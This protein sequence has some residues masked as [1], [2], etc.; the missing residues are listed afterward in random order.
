MQHP[1][2]N[3]LQG[4]NNIVEANLNLFFKICNNPLIS[5]KNIFSRLRVLFL[6]KLSV[7]DFVGTE[8]LQAGPMQCKICGFGRYIQ[9]LP[10]HFFPPRSCFETK[11]K[12]TYEENVLKLIH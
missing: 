1:V 2:K 10:G 9:H 7:V 8:F 11:G 6:G 12:H 5:L 3:I 4:R